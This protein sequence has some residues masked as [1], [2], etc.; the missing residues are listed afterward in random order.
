MRAKEMKCFNGFDETNEEKKHSN[1][2]VKRN[3]DGI[4]QYTRNAIVIEFT[5]KNL[6]ID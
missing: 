5:K 6:L 1:W 2:K 3:C 4:I